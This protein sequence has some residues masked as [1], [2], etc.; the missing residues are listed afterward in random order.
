[1]IP[2]F[3]QGSGK[4][5]GHGLKS[6]LERFESIAC[7][8]IRSNRV[9]AFALIF[10]DFEDYDVRRI[11]KDQGVF[12]ELDRLSRKDLSVFYLHSGSQH[13]IEKFNS[14]LLNALGATPEANPPCVVFF[15]VTDGGFSEISIAQLESTDLIHGFHELYGIIMN[16]IDT[17]GKPDNPKYIQ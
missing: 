10:Y 17:N 11:L 13:S 4:G 3:E 9:K 5:I 8:H 14:V 15:K 1:M 16:Y 2:M 7:E 6:F 12:A